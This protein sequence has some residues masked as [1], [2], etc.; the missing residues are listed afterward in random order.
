[1]NKT[2]GHQNVEDQVPMAMDT[3]FRIFSMT[4]P[5]TGTALMI[6]HDEGKFQLS[7]P[8]SKYIP[9]LA[10]VKVFTESDARWRRGIAGL[11]A[12]LAWAAWA[13][14]DSCEGFIVNVMTPLLLSS[15]SVGG[16]VSLYSVLFFWGLRAGLKIFAVL[17]VLPAVALYF[18]L[19]ATEVT[20]SNKNM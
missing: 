11:V 5:I 7:D 8:V 13:W 15:I 3:I 6:L 16:F 17:V 12:F 19:V 1:M 9:E 20:S 14:N 4:K 18:S 10:D 2:F